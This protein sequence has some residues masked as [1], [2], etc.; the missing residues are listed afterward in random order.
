MTH[1]SLEL[2]LNDILESVAI[3]RDDVAGTALDAFELD[4]RQQLI[5]ERYIEI[6]SAASR[7][8][9]AEMTARHPD[10]LWS[11]VAGIGNALR[12]PKLVAQIGPNER[13]WFPRREAVGRAR[14]NPGE[15]SSSWSCQARRAHRPAHAGGLGRAQGAPCGAPRSPR[16]IR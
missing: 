3:A 9:P 16:R 6:I 14:C 13:S 12:R 5:V 15:I 4:R 7:P 1:H 8:V 10:I 2:R 11:R